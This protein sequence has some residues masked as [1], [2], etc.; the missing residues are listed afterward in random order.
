[1]NIYARGHR[2]CTGCGYAKKNGPVHRWFDTANNRW[3]FYRSCRWCG[4][5]F[6]A[7]AREWNENHPEMDPHPVRYG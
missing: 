5:C 2:G 7:T 6:T 3:R 1:M 4:C